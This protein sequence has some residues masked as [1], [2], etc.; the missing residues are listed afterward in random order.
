MK[1]ITHNCLLPL[2]YLNETIFFPIRVESLFYLR[3]SVLSASKAWEKFKLSLDNSFF[4]LLLTYRKI[5]KI[6]PG[7]IFFKG[8][9][10]GGGL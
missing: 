1:T 8:H 3:I 9:F 4:Y 5:P 6:S 10:L 7:L 2:N